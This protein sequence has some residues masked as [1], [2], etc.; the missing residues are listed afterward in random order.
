MARYQYVILAAAVPGREAE[1]EHWYDEQHLADVV[2]IEGVVNARR[3]RIVDQKVT[4]LDAP[5]W[6]SLAIYDI[7]SE[8]PQAVLA[9]ISAAAGT[10]AMPLTEAMTRTGLVQL[11]VQQ[12]SAVE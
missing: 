6:R 8:D 10:D 2:N 7:E 9:T 12:V 11:L 5:G 4:N 1:F 3:F